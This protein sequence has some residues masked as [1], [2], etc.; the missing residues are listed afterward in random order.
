MGHLLA[1]SFDLSTKSLPFFAYCK[2]QYRIEMY[3]LIKLLQN[4]QCV[5]FQAIQNTILQ[6]EMKCVQICPFTL[7]V[8][9]SNFLFLCVRAC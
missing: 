3:C 9:G 2:I 1:C 6:R 4:R 5:T 7:A 8:V